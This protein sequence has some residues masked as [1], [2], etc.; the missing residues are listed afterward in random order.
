MLL[1]DRCRDSCPMRSSIVQCNL[2][3]A[4]RSWAAAPTPPR[5]GW[6]AC[7]PRCCSRWGPRAWSSAATA[8]TTT[9]RATGCTSRRAHALPT[10]D[11]ALSWAPRLFVSFVQGFCG[12]RAHSNSVLR[13]L[14]ALLGVMR[15]WGPPCYNTRFL[16]VILQPM[17][18][19]VYCSGVQ[20]AWGAKRAAQ[21]IPEFAKRLVA[22]YDRDGA[23]TQR[24]ARGPCAEH[25][26]GKAGSA[27]SCDVLKLFKRRS[28]CEPPSTGVVMQAGS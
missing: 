14:N 28:S 6:A 17:T 13:T 22:Q 18:L 7:W 1:S 21:H 16:S 24:C 23:L 20:R 2:F 27:V 25:S 12:E 26:R 8:S 11:V 5:A 19:S 4:G 9:T 15:C 10:S 3:A